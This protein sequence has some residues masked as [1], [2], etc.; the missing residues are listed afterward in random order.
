MKRSIELSVSPTAS[1]PSGS[2]AADISGANE[3]HRGKLFLLD[4]WPV[5]AFE[6]R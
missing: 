1:S 3:P 6:R 5:S 4:P 2:R